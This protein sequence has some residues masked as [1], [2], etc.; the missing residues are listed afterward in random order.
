[1]NIKEIAFKAG[2]AENQ[3][4]DAAALKKLSTAKSKSPFVVLLLER[5]EQMDRAEEKWEQL[6]QNGSI[7]Q[8]RT[9]AMLLFSLE[10]CTVSA[11]GSFGEKA[12]R[13]ALTE[14]PQLELCPAE[15]ELK[16]KGLLR[17]MVLC[18]LLCKPVFPKAVSRACHRL[19]EYYESFPE[20]MRQAIQWHI[21]A[22]RLGNMDSKYALGQMYLSGNTCIKKD[23]DKAFFWISR[24]AREGHKIAQFY[25]GYCYQNGKNVEQNLEAAFTWYLKSAKQGYP[26]AQYAVGEAYVFGRGVRENK[27]K[28]FSWYEKAAILGHIRSQS[29]L[30]HCYQEGKMVQKDPVTAFQW[31]LKAAKQGHITAQAR[32]GRAFA[33]GDGVAQDFKQ[34][35]IWAQY[36][37]GLH[38]QNGWG[39]EK[40]PETAF[41]WYLK[42]AEQ[43]NAHAQN[44]IGWSYRNGCGVE[45]NIEEAVFWYK[46]AA[47]QGNQYAQYNLG[48]CYLNGQ[49]VEKNPETAFQ[50]YLKAAEQGYADAQ[51]MV[52][53]SYGTGCGVE[54]N[55]EEAV[56]W[57]KKAAEQGNHRGAGIR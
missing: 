57:Y 29:I 55:M 2:I 40:N 13:K 3:I 48:F 56:F 12:L 45:Q 35:A 22:V 14:I 49:G 50:W 7:Q 32:V 21:Y 9:Q 8:L 11:N 5:A 19:G 17:N 38:Y 47:E 42:A 39:V 10:D 24:A 52:G 27:A 54:Q 26:E 34:A 31:Y 33:I 4:N 1:M 15:M 6:L 43:G 53:W 28:A 30:G 20:A 18:T 46:K 25:L 41:Q 51:Q 37:L 16:R 44:N 36:N 23:P